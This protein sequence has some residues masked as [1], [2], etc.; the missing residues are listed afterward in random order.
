[1]GSFVL[2]IIQRKTI[3]KESIDNIRYLK[4]YEQGYDGPPAI[5][6]TV[7]GKRQTPHFL[8]LVESMNIDDAAP[9][10]RENTLRRIAERHFNAEARLPKN[11]D[12]SNVRIATHQWKPG[13]GN[14]GL[15]CEIE[16]VQMTP[17]GISSL[18]Y[19]G[20][21]NTP[22]A[23]KPAYERN[24]VEFV[25]RN[26]IAAII[27]D[28]K[29][30]V[31]H[32][33]GDLYKEQMMALLQ[34]AGFY[35]R[36]EVFSKLNDKG[37]K[38]A[39][40]VKGPDGSET[41]HYNNVVL[42]AHGNRITDVVTDPETVYDYHNTT[43][44]K[45]LADKLVSD[46]DL[47]DR[48]ADGQAYVSCRING[49]PQSPKAVAPALLDKYER[50]IYDKT[51]VAVSMFYNEM[52]G[53]EKTQRI[54]VDMGARVMDGKTV[55]YHGGQG[56][57]G[58]F[59]KDSEAFRQ[60][61][62]ICYMGEGAYEDYERLLN[63]GAEI[64][65]E[66]FG[67]TYKDILDEARSYAF[68][69]PEE[70][71]QYVF[72]H[73]GG[74]GISTDMEQLAANC[75]EEEL[76]NT[77]EEMQAKWK[78]FVE[79]HGKQPNYARVYVQ[80]EGEDNV[81]EHDI[82]LNAVAGDYADDEVMFTC[83]SPQE[84]FRLEKADNGED[85]R[86]VEFV[87]YSLGTLD[88]NMEQYLS[89][90]ELVAIERENSY[91]DDIYVVMVHRNGKADG[92]YVKPDG[93]IYDSVTGLNGQK[94]EDVLGIELAHKVFEM[95]EFET[96]DIETDRIRSNN[97]VTDMVVKK[98]GEF[99]YEQ[100]MLR[101]KINGVQQSWQDITLHDYRSVVA[102]GSREERE[103]A[104]LKLVYRYFTDELRQNNTRELEQTHGFKR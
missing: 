59:Y 6:C 93:T 24:M 77:Q 69:H 79:S 89:D 34:R 57:H 61:D 40:A 67:W 58:T 92:C 22:D 74:Y 5:T 100:G 1:M 35:P 25:Y 90:N 55:I 45:L 78:W 19:A 70:M 29:P 75:S 51:Q 16:G 76:M 28:R 8:T 30:M 21:K 42:L 87:S 31:I 48:H 80:W 66:E 33:K 95:N 99:P 72:D 13:T 3:M 62:G 97:Q 2:I 43:L 15:F 39:T 73:A 53:T 101:C 94:L 20:W 46:V 37:L 17:K 56:E 63:E 88:E 64:N 18:M 23:E 38:G 9:H 98:K 102:A 12:I 71:A 83:S 68:R 84:F 4:P 47:T 82:A 103:A 54:E 32:M 52:L 49:V 86:I 27:R 11:V 50:G 65:I 41:R 81:E 26:E 91:Q 96:L 10:E 104:K 60:K 14:Y 36:D 44:A 85:F 7:N